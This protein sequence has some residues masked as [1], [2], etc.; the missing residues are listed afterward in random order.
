M[1]VL[2]QKVGDG[3]A[4]I[5]PLGEVKSC[6]GTV[7]GDELKLGRSLG[8]S[9]FGAGLNHTRGLAAPWK[10]IKYFFENRMVSKGL[11]IQL[12]F[13]VTYHI[14]NGA[15]EMVQ[16]PAFEIWNCVEVGAHGDL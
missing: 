13:D 3:T 10:F 11:W 9:A 14:V 12:S 2:H 16:G 1:A 7:G 6:L 15:E 5:L 4:S 8:S